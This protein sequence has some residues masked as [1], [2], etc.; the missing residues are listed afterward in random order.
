MS[1]WYV[2]YDGSLSS[3]SFLGPWKLFI[4][5]RSFVVFAGDFFEVVGFG[6]TA[7][8]LEDLLPTSLDSSLW[9][10]GAKANTFYNPTLIDLAWALKKWKGCRE[11]FGLVEV[12]WYHYPSSGFYRLD[13]VT[14]GKMVMCGLFL[15]LRKGPFL[16]FPCWVL[17][18]S[19]VDRSKKI[20]EVSTMV[21]SGTQVSPWMVW[22]NR[23][24][25]VVGQTVRLQPHPLCRHLKRSCLPRDSQ[26]TPFWLQAHFWC[27]Q[28]FS[29][30]PR[31]HIRMVKLPHSWAF[32]LV[33]VRCFGKQ[34]VIPDGLF[35]MT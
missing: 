18:I 20:A 22:I 21:T 32:A 13:V 24:R 1:M 7:K 28:W 31:T 19:K 14:T 6:F 12:E 4:W 8:N 35:L 15:I 25:K 3:F 29:L 27:S 5:E 11:R 16:S 2:V 33:S 10:L 26:K 17:G 30:S 23:A 9:L 34:A